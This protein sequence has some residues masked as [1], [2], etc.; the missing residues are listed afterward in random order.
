MARFLEWQGN[1]GRWIFCRTGYN[2]EDTC[3]RQGWVGVSNRHYWRICRDSRE[4]EAYSESLRRR[5]VTLA[6]GWGERKADLAYLGFSRKE[7][8]C[9]RLRR[10]YG[11]RLG[12][13]GI[14]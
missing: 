4:H 6:Y 9:S 2:G 10:L 3:V 8:E 1:G 14:E 5:F 11:Y 13:A 7:R 12:T